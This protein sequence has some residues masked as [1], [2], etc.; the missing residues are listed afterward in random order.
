[1]KAR[2]VSY[3]VSRNPTELGN[4]RNPKMNARLV[5]RRVLPTTSLRD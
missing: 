5:N 1:M 2:R 4:M 3:L